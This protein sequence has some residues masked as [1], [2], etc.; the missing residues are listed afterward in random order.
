MPKTL[1]LDALG[2]QYR[3]ATAAVSAHLRKQA[4]AELAVAA[5]LK[6]HRGIPSNVLYTPT[7]E[8]LDPELQALEEAVAKAE[9]DVAWCA[10]VVVAAMEAYKGEPI[11]DTLARNEAHQ[12]RVGGNVAAAMTTRAGEER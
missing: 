12:H 10:A 2:A 5:W 1:D 11:A 8:P 9:L 4:D 6:A 7:G 3:E